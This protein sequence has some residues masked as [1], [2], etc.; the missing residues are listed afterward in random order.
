MKQPSLLHFLIKFS[1]FIGNKKG[2]KSF[3]NAK[4]VSTVLQKALS[5]IG[6]LSSA[7][8]HSRTWKKMSSDKTNLDQF[9]QLRKVACCLFRPGNAC[10]C[11]HMHDRKLD[12]I[13]ENHLK[14]SKM[15]FFHH[16]HEMCKAYVE[17]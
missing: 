4:K 6:L 12:K 9:Q 2:Q 5:I 1:L 13:L 11:K 16:V 17:T 7:H 15:Y 14:S 3:I 8:S 10:L